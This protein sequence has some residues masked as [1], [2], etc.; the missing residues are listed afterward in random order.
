MDQ[1]KRPAGKSYSEVMN[2]WAAQR[3]FMGGNRSRLLHPPFDAHPVRKVLGYLGRLVVVIVIPLVIYLVLLGSHV[4]SKEFNQMISD[5][6]ATV[7]NADKVTAHGGFWEFDGIL[8]LKSMK[9]TGSSGAFFEQLEAQGIATRVPMPMVFRREWILPRVSIEDLSISLRSGGVGQV[10]LYELKAD[11]DDEVRLPSLP[12]AIDSAPKTGA[13]GLPPTKV[14]RA[15]YGVS[16]D[17]KALRINAVQTSH[18]NVTWGSSP[19]TVGGVTGMQTDLA[20]TSAG[21]VISGNG[22]QFRQG[23][24]DGMKVEKLAVTIAPGKAVMDEVRLSHAGGGKAGITGSMTL[25]ELPVLDAELKLEEVRLQDLV[26][27]SAGSIFTAMASGTV[28]L[29]GSVN[30]SSGIRMEGTL[31]LQ[32]GRLNTLPVF[33]ALSQITKEDQFRRLSLQSGTLTFSTSGSEEHGGLIVEIKAFEWA[34]GPMVRL[35]GNYRQE[36]IREIGNPDG[37]LPGERMKIEGLLQIGMPAMVLAKIKPAVAARYFKSGADGWSW[38]DVAIDGPVTGN[39]SREL[40][41]ELLKA[42]AD[43]P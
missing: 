13:R 10:P 11:P 18:L 24:L 33:D 29:S 15:G 36:Q 16:P 14:L 25:G 42:V 39:L 17:F 6:I 23:W 38:L 12:P 37:K 7:L 26:A 30:R 32:S 9:A 40:A 41:A 31:D 1:P 28:K 8:A 2:E 19:A 5:G 34:C 21:W 27:V 3:E 22:G 4:K 43:S 35:K 20:R